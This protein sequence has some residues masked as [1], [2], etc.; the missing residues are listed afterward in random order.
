MDLKKATLNVPTLDGPN[1]GIY[2]THL[3]A[4]AR[5]L[6]CWDVTKGEI[7]SAIGAATTIYDRLEYPTATVFADAK[8]LVVAKA[9]WNKKNAQA[10]GLMQTTMAPALWISYPSF[11]RAHDLWEKLETDFGQVGGALTNL[12]MVNMT[13]LE[14]V[15]STEL[16]PQIQQ[17]LENYNRI[18]SNGHSKFPEDLTTFTFCSS[19]PASYEQ[20]A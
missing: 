10:M 1:W 17:F 5:I 9:T 16:L 6:E 19:L 15:N 3:Q 14:F 18:T 7:S 20:T 11:G 8:D 12:Q 2:T 13:K 4:A